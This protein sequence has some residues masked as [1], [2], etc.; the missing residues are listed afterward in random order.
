MIPDRAVVDMAMGSGDRLGVKHERLGSA[1][2]QGFSF[3][4]QA[5]G[6]VD[7][8]VQHGVGDGRIADDLVPVLDRHLAGDDGRAALVPVVHDLQQ[9]AALLAGERRQAP[10]VQD[11]Q[12]HPAERLQQPSIAPVAAGQASAS[13]SL[14]TR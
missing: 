11:Q 8:P 5:M 1:F 7:E 2:S 4:Q 10:I 13:S 3:Q 6:V 14:G 12:L 9:V